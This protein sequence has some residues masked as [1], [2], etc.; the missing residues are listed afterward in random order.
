L[1]LEL[2]EQRAGIYAIHVPYEGSVPVITEL[3]GGQVQHVLA[4][5]T[6]AR[7][8]LKGNR[9]MAIARTSARSHPNV[10]GS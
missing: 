5:M 10:T 4:T 8:H 3:I 7:P 1:A 9:L 6:A 2:F